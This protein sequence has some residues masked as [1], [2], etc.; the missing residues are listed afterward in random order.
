MIVS[1]DGLRELLLIEISTY[2]YILQNKLSGILQE[3]SVR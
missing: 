3:D 2:L 1:L